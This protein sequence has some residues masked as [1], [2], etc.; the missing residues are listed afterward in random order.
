MMRAT[1]RPAASRT[2]QIVES[3]AKD[4]QLPVATPIKA[5]QRKKAGRAPV[6]QT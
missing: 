4:D 2:R 6:L 3:M 5:L 1:S